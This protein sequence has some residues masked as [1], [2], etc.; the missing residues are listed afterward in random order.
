MTVL[1]ERVPIPAEFL[2][3]DYSSDSV[4][5]KG[6]QRWVSDLWQDKDETLKALHAGEPTSGS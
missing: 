4:F 1:V 5:R 2:G 3:K 6:L